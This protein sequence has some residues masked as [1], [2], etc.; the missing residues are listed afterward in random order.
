MLIIDS[1]HQAKQEMM[2]E[3]AEKNG[4]TDFELEVWSLHLADYTY[5][6]IAAELRITPNTVKNH[7]KNIHTKQKSLLAKNK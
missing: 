5:K 3:D 4:L 6:E 7:L 2:M 1:K